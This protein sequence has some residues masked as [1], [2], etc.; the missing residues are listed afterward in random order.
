MVDEVVWRELLLL[1]LVVGQGLDCV[2]QA[3]ALSGRHVTLGR[4]GK[5]ITRPVVR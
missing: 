1:V 2:E 3:Q 4:R 5:T